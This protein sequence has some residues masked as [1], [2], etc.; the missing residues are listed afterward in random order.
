MVI[1]LLV[2]TACNNIND[3]YNDDTI[4]IIMRVAIVMLIISAIVRMI[5][6]T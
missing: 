6:M 5:K 4:K 2:A 1:I 3:D